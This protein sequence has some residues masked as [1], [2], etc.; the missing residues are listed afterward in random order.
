MI[1]GAAKNFHDV[2]VICDPSDYAWVMEEYSRSGGIDGHGR[3]YLAEKVFRTMSDY[4][5]AIADYLRGETT[6]SY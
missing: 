6:G 1:R 4:D 5:G 3:R 2:L